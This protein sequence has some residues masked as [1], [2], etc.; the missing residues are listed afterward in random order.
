[1]LGIGAGFLLFRRHKKRGNMAVAMAPAPYPPTELHAQYKH[2][3]AGYYTPKPHE[4]PLMSPVEL[5]HRGDPYGVYPN[6]EAGR[7]ANK[8]NGHVRYEM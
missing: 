5:G 6:H 3:E 7:T 2:H 1:V 8:N 4:A